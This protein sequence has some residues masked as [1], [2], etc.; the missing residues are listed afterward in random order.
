MG[1]RYAGAPRAVWVWWTA[2]LIAAIGYGIALA[3]IALEL[4]I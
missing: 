4:P 1:S 3:V 2:G